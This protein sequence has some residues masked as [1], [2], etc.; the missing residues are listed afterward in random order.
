M[1]W[2]RL[3]KIKLTYCMGWGLQ[4]VVGL[5]WEALVLC[6]GTSF[7]RAFAVVLPQIHQGNSEIGCPQSLLP[8]LRDIVLSPLELVDIFSWSLFLQKIVWGFL[9]KFFFFLPHIHFARCFGNENHFLVLFQGFSNKAKDKT[10]K[11]N[12]TPQI[13]F[14]RINK[15]ASMYHHYPRLFLQFLF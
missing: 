7:R 4:S 10:K 11:K 3:R 5:V 8:Q 13:P 2:R 12:K 9:N 14:F 1:K 15:K 6:P